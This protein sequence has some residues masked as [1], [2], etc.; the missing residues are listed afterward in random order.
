MLPPD[1]S[2]HTARIRLQKVVVAELLKMKK[3]IKDEAVKLADADVDVIGFGCT[4]GSLVAGHGY[5]DKIVEIIEKTTG[6]LAVA[7]AGAVV[8]AL[9][10]LGLSSVSVVTPYTD[11]L[12]RLER[13]FLEQNG[14]QVDRIAGLNL[15]DNL[16]I[17]EVK[18]R[19]LLKLVREVDSKR[20]DG[21][22]ISCTNLHTIAMIARL[23]ESLKKPVVS[24]NTA[25]LW[26][27]LGKVGKSLQTNKYGKLFLSS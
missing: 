24:S 27:M 11:V 10:A 5:D 3:D 7:T 4:T 23:E 2:V 18:P 26:A 16:K 6:K 19:T 9:K 21:I 22:F 20:A 1:M 13:Q 12:N 14:F 8:Q 25:T 17:A 15:V